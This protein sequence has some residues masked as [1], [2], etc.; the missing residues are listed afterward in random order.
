MAAPTPTVFGDFTPGQG[1]DAANPGEE[2][3][4][5]AALAPPGEVQAAPVTEAAENLAVCNGFFR[6]VIS[7][8]RGGSVGETSGST[9]KRIGS[10]PKQPGR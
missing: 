2:A 4:N 7:H 6:G 10:T 5:V 9:P 1:S 8:G 3:A